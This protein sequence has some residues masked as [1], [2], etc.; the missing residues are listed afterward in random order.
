MGR[1]RSYKGHRKRDCKCGKPARVGQR[2]CNEC[3]AAYQRANRRKHN[4]L[5]PE[6]KKK[7]VARAYLG[8]YLR[9]GKVVKSGCAICG[10][11]KVEAHHEDYDKPLEV[12]WLCRKHHTEL[13]GENTARY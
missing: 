11:L 3:H 13:H 9:R 12:I 7:A 10:D 2:Y 1:D 4:E 5:N 8:V 6:Q